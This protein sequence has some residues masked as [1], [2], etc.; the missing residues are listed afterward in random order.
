MSRT[1]PSERPTTSPGRAGPALAAAAL[2]VV[3][4]ALGAPP[5]QALLRLRAPEISLR[6]TELYPDDAPP[7]DTVKR[8]VFERVNEDRIAAG[9][10]AVRWDEAAARAA[11][12]FCARQAAEKTRGHFLTDGVPPYAR[13]SFAG[14]FGM[15]SENSVSWVTTAESFSEPLVKLALE[16]HAEMIRERAPGDGHR[17]TI[18]DPYATHVGVGYAAAQGRFQMA[19]EFLT[20]GLRSLS[21]S[22]L[23]GGATGV[24]VEGRPLSELTLR[25]VTIAWEPSPR[26]LTRQEAS[27]RTSYSY[28]SAQLSYIPEGLRSM[29]VSGTTSEDRLKIRADRSF[30]FDFVPSRGGLYSLVFY[31]SAG[32]SKTPRPGASAVLWFD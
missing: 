10:R 12:D 8:A 24:F 3:G 13:T 30:A 18:L 9:L 14:V 32:P 1:N 2:G 16:G 29:R 19:Q 31:L 15:G 21:L 17:R 27:G 4:L 25:F 6:R 11:D 20:R 5:R 7:R 26:P 23:S 28:P 22:P